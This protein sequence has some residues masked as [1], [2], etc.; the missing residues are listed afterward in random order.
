MITQA[1]QIAGNDRDAWSV[2]RKLAE[3]T[4][5]NLEWK[6]VVSADPVSTLATREADCTEF[7][8]LFV[9]MAR[10][11]GLPARTVSGL[12]YNGGSFGG[13]AWVEVWVGKWIELDPTWGTSF[14]DATHV[15]TASDSLLTAASLN[16]L[17]LEVLEAKR[18][19]AEFQKNPRALAEHLAKAIPA[20]DRSEIEAAIDVAVLTDT[21]MG[22]GAWAKLNDA[23]REQMWSAYRRLLTEIILGYKSDGED[24]QRIRVLHVEEKGDTAE[25]ICLAEP[26]EML[27]KFRFVRRDGVWYLVEMAQ[28]DN[29]FAFAS[30]ILRPTIST[31]EKTRA[32]EKAPS[33]GLSDFSRVMLLLERDSAKAVRV[34][35]ELLKPKPQDRDLRFLKAAALLAQDKD[36]EAVKLLSEL[37]DEGHVPAVY[38]LADYLSDSEEEKDTQKRLELYQ[39]CPTLEPRDPRGFRDLA[40]AYAFERSAEAEVA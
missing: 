39:R 36:E 9:G 22:A 10:S 1:R 34:A 15:R 30:E 25:A 24:E 14:V 2:A 38:R 3:W 40:G 13:H 29:G 6:L 17:E 28:A 21:H 5:K 23:E 4:H 33:L 31:I 7:S 8:A 32:G 37:A 19:V 26:V 27:V 16:L 12:A 18:T 11:L 20:T 35:D